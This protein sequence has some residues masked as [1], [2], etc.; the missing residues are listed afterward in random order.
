MAYAQGTYRYDGSGLAGI[1]GTLDIANRI[2]GM[3]PNGKMTLYEYQPA[4]SA[5]Y[6]GACYCQKQLISACDPWSGYYMLDSGFYMSLHFSQ[7]IEKGW[8]F[9]DSGCYSDG[10]KGGDGHAIVDAVYSYMTA[11][12]TETGDYSTVITNTTSEPIQ[13]DLKVSGLDKASSNVSVWETRGPDSIDGSYN[14]NYFKKTEDITPTENGGAYT[15]SVTVKPN[16]IVTISTVTPERTEYKNADESE[17]TVLKLPYSD[18]FEYAGYSENYLSSRG[19]AP[20][21]TTDQGG[22]FEVEKTDK[23]NMLVQQITADMKANEWGYT[24]EPVTTFGDDRWYNYS[25]NVDA[26]FATSQDAGSNY[27]GVGLRYTLGCNSY[28]GYWIKL[29]E[30][31]SWELKANDSTLSSG[32]ID[33]FDGTASHKLKVEAVNNV[34]RGYVDGNMVAEYTV[35]EGESLIGAGR[36]SLFSSYNKNSFDNFSAEPVEGS[37]T[38]VT[39]FDETDSCFTFEG[40]WEHNLM[41]SFKNYK[42]SISDGTEGDS[43]TVSLEGTGFALSGE[44]RENAILGVSIDGGDEQLVTV[45]RTGQREISCHFEGLSEGAHT[46]KVTIKSGKYTIDAMQVTGGKIPF[47]KKK[48]AKSE[49]TKSGKSKLPIAV[50]AGVCAAAVV[51]AV[52][53]GIARKKRKENND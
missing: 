5:Y 15:Y 17:R 23:G 21:Y 19:N 51:G 9:V 31:G 50:G 41:S 35:N 44:T 42:R 33:G 53:Y 39:R 30:N 45:S 22:A 12:D 29:Y 26:A 20:R 38:Y 6:D 24:P 4:V 40:N 11:T 8:A 7:F 16:S 27:V 47:E 46:A 2:I 36:A 28:S 13:Y 10:K 14:E 37:D 25:V 52:I 3:Y 34:I 32:S 18:D 49:S 1:N 43:F 48:P